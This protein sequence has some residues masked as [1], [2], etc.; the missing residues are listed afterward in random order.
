MAAIDQ[1]TKQTTSSGQCVTR[2]KACYWHTLVL[3]NA[4]C[5]TDY[6]K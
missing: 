5:H 3:I 4:N 6:K 2:V 1:G